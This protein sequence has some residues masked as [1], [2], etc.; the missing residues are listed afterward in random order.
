MRF[1]DAKIMIID[2]FSAMGAEHEKSADALELM[3]TFRQVTTQVNGTVIVAH[4]TPKRNG[5]ELLQLP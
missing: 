5:S 3:R 4:H 1:Y 2:N